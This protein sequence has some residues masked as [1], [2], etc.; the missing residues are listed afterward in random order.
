MDFNSGPES[1]R[2]SPEPGGTQRPAAGGAGG[3]FTLSDPVGS[4]IRTYVSV[5]TQPI[6]FFRGIARQ[7]DFINPLVYTLICVLISAF[8]T[9]I[10]GIIFAPLF[11]GPGD[12]AEA[13]AGGIG[14]VL[15]GLILTPIYTAIVLVIVAGIHPFLL[16]RF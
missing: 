14:G 12:T 11:A 6:P 9:G 4:F 2:S 10:L 7:G 5:V 1:G 16:L 8:L 3:E 13:F 15:V